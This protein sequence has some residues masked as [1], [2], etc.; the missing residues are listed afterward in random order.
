MTIM[1]LSV[2]VAVTLAIV[3]LSLKQLQLSVDTRDS[4]VAF[5]AANAGL[6]CARYWRRVAS[7]SLE[8]PTG[9]GVPGGVMECMSSVSSSSLLRTSA[10]GD[11][12][13]VTGGT[14]GRFTKSMTWNLNRCSVIDMLVIVSGTTSS[15]VV[16]A[17][18]GNL[19]QVFANYPT[20]SKTCPPGA[21]CTIV[22][23]AGYNSSCANIN[24]AGTL[25]REVL[26]EF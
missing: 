7:T 23:A 4:E 10:S 26:L 19:N 8:A 13:D 12:L 17:E 25:K 5:H 16:T 24:T 20:A 11:G 9:T 21:K 15:A 2:V 18:A 1:V 6:E 3:E 14:I 22:S